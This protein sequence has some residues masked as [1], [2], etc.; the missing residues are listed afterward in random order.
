MSNFGINHES[1]A[2]KRVMVHHPGKELE[3][4][5]ADPV[6]HHFDQPVDIKQFISI[7]SS[8]GEHGNRHADAFA[9]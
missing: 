8:M 6:A 3:L 2:L 4:A 5:N 1:G 7:T 9:R